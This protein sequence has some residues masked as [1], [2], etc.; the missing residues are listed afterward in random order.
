MAVLTYRLWCYTVI[1]ARGNVRL[2]LYPFKRIIRQL[3][4]C[5]VDLYAQPFFLKVLPFIVYKYTLQLPF[6]HSHYH[7]IYTVPRI[8]PYGYRLCP[9]P[10]DN[11]TGTIVTKMLLLLIVAWC[12]TW[13]QPLLLITNFWST[14]FQRE[15]IYT[16]KLES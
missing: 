11:S 5:A 12:W 14:E 2:T 10:Y 9:F 3:S 13:K 15:N 4:D 8:L 7:I 1:A 6:K 16:F